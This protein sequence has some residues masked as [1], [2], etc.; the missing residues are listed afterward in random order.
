MN[1]S[2]KVADIKLRNFKI[3]MIGLFKN[4]HNAVRNW[5]K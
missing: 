2:A 4:A 1:I 3:W 5:E